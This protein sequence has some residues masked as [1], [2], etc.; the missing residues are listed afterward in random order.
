MASSDN[1]SAHPE[2][3][4]A[5]ASEVDGIADE[6][7]VAL[8]AAQTVHLD[9]IAYG[10]LCQQIPMMMEPLTAQVVNALRETVDALHDTGDRLHTASFDY[11]GT[12]NAA[13]ARLD[14]AR[15]AR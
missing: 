5:H 8:S 2:Q 9:T 10:L 3:I 13:A 14:A 12:D 6:V 1:F 7:A 11:D 15:D 4:A